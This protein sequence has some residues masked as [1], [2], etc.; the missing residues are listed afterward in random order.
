VT[1]IECPGIEVVQC[2]ELSLNDG[3]S[4]WVPAFDCKACP[5]Y[6]GEII[7]QAGR[8]TYCGF[9]CPRSVSQRRMGQDGARETF[10]SLV[11]SKALLC[12]HDIRGC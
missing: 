12:D 11:G 3:K 1:I 7:S 2:P 8:F 6:A 10:H 9:S 4:C 5:W